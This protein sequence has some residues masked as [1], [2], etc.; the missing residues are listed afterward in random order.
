MTTYQP[1]L[2]FKDNAAI[3]NIRIK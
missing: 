2:N 3:K 1:K